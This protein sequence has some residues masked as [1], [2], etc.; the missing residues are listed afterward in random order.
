MS[1]KFL[2]R[3]RD[4]DVCNPQLAHLASPFGTA[5][6]DSPPAQTGWSL[7]PTEINISVGHFALPVCKETYI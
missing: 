2:V 3:S 7:V 4:L 6:I 5:D 1:F